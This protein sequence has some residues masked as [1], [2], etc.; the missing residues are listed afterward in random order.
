MLEEIEGVTN[1]G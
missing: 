1:N